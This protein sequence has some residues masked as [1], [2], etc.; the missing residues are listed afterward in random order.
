MVYL[1]N[2]QISKIL[3]IQ[4]FIFSVCFSF[5]IVSP[6]FAQTEDELFNSVPLESESNLEGSSNSALDDFMQDDDAGQGQSEDTSLESNSEDTSFESGLELESTNSEASSEDSSDELDAIEDPAITE[7]MDSELSEFE[8]EVESEI[9]ADPLNAPSPRRP[10]PNSQS[11]NLDDSITN[12]VQSLSGPNVKNSRS[13]R[14]KLIKHPGQ[15]QGLYKISADGR[16]Y[17]KVNESKQKYGVA[18]KGGAL[19]LNQLEAIDGSPTFGDIYG[20]GAK[21]SVYVEYYWSYFKNKNVPNILKKARVKL[22][23]GLLFA[24]GKGQFSNPNYLGVES[25][26][27]LTFLAFPNTIGLHLSFEVKDKQLIVPFATA[28]LDYLVAIEL[29]NDNLSRTKFLGQLGAHFGGGVALSLGWLEET[30]KFDLDAEWGINQTYLIVELRQNV[31]IQTDFDFT[32]TSINAGI[33]FE[34]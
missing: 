34:F 31:A 29:Q 15:K 22:G 20:G 17:Y 19:V 6:A 18:I 24:T 13:K 30:A 5:L 1:K 4:K 11:Q 12:D 32:A 8:S 9:I 10:N 26:E 16:Y 3:I 25:G 23:S 14:I 33:Q 27:T 7:E 28:G 21:P 2:T